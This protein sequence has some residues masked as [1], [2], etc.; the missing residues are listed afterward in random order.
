[1]RMLEARPLKFYFA[2]MKTIKTALFCLALAA[3][4]LASAGLAAARDGSPLDLARQLNEAFIQVADEASASVVVIQV[5]GKTSDGDS[6]ESSSFWNSLPP[7][8][9]RY[10]EEHG[11][12][13]RNAPHKF[14]GEGSGI[15]V[16]PDGYILTNNHVVENADKIIVR[17]KDGREFTAAV[18]GTD[19][20]SDVALLKIPATGLTP[21]KLGDSDATRVGEFVLAVGAPFTLSYSVTFGH[22]SAK[23]RSFEKELGDVYADQ[24]F[25]QTDASINP[26]N[27]G[28]PLVNLYGQVIAINTMIEGMNTGIGFA[29]PI[30]LAKRVMAHLIDEGKYT[31]SWLGIRID[32]LRDDS[33]YRN[34]RSRLAPDVHDG[35]VV[36]SIGPHTPAAKSD[37]QAGDVITAVDDKPVT[38]SR[39]LKDEIAAKPPGHVTVLN[40]VRATQHLAIKVTV[41]ALVPEPE[42]ASESSTP[43]G[44]AE[45]V[46]LG[47]TVE[48]MSKR[49]AGQYGI[50]EVS[51]VVI[52][53]V[54]PDSAAE[55][56]DIKPGDVITEINRKHVT[57]PRQFRDAIKSADA[58]TGIMVNLIRDGASRFVVLKDNGK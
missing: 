58:E 14:H 13:R 38:T 8:F 6:D 24:D 2:I 21:A 50:D 27:S 56:S 34:L 49:L 39:Q 18:K 40:V 4:V 17:F 28:G 12:R 22:V 46:S 48:S 19:P 45:A 33:D 36:V 20:E 1:M 43:S 53:A 47:I 30:N 16:S 32:D 52:T 54:E 9:R 26:G 42:M 25:I 44:Q 57:T 41:A 3:A 51:G 23:G 29:I 15:V 55:E 10:F 37:L 11:G 5:T 7:E 35:V 31:R